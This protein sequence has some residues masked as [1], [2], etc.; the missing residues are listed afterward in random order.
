MDRELPISVIVIDWQ[1][2]VHQGDWQFN[3]VCWPDPQGMVDEL[4][5]LGIET[6]VTFWPFQTTGSINWPEFS[7]SGYLVSNLNGTLEPYDG[8]QYLVDETNP[9]V[10]AAVFD[11]FWQGYGHLGIKT[12]WIDAAEPE[13]FGGASEGTWKML[14]GTDAEVGEAW[15]QQHAKMLHDGF[16]SKGIGAGDYFILPRSAWAGTWRYSAALWSGDIQS[17]FDELAIQIKVLQG[18][19]MSGPAL[20]TTDIG[21]YWDGDSS[22][23]VFQEL[24]VRWFQFGAFSPLFRLHGHRAGGPP[25]NECG[26]TNGDNEVWNLATEPAHY[27]GI[28]AVMRLRENL[29]QYVSDINAQAAATGMPMCRPMFLEFPLDAGCQ[30]ADVE[31]QFMFGS[32][33]LVAPVYAYQ[34]A[35]RS[36]YLPALP[37]NHEWIYFFGERPMGPGGARI[38]V[39]TT[40]I[41]EFPLF[42][43]RPTVPP[44]PPALGEMTQYY[45]AERN[46]TVLCLDA[47]CTNANQPGSPGSYVQQRVEALGLLSDDGTGHTTIGNVSYPLRALTL[48]YSFTHDDNLVTTNTTAPDSSYTSGTVF[49]NGFVLGA[50]APGALP[51]QLFF[52]HFA[53]S[54]QDY[55][56]V[57][58]P[59]GVAWAQSHGY[60]LVD[61]GGASGGGWVLPAQ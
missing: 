25:A 20:W 46:D 45:S 17:T 11:K 6:M 16:A 14:A 37:P 60:A 24:I 40:N 2:W 47:A 51:L 52:K 4:S 34:A 38:T 9:E 48:Y 33:W 8:D 29:R 58:S 53:G 42:F 18:V 26:P 56:T 59:A 3:P 61:A 28:V 50:A 22:N 31:D 12:V 35:S 21:G 57:A 32:S 39:P 19:M 55:L 49:P 7:S 5:T 54:N 13:H 41:T 27:A 36:V 44:Q 30:G 1:H 15:V 10:R 23:P 43:V